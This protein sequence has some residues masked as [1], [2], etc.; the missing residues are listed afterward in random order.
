MSALTSLSPWL[1]GV[2]VVGVGLLIWSIGAIAADRSL[3]T[4]TLSE[5]N[6]VGG[7]NFSFLEPV[8]AVVL[9]YALPLTWSNYNGLADQIGIESSALRVIERTAAGLPSPLDTRLEAAVRSYAAAVAASE[10]PAME[11]GQA[12]P[13][14]AAALERL[15][16]VF[17][18]ARAT[19]P[20]ETM[21][22]RL[23]QRLLAKVVD[24][25]SARLSLVA[26]KDGPA[27]W[28]IAVVVTLAVLAFTWFFG[29]PTLATK[30]VMGGL[31]VAA[32]MTIVYVIF[33]LR[34]PLSGTLGLPATP[35]LALAG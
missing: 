4:V 28:A 32:V 27:T 19:G 12:S 16:S 13:E 31:F 34:H 17:G 22:L 8:L 1:V 25:R 35:Y 14:A 33:I 24:S 21:A 11:N 6:V 7:F 18:D 23:S 9:F 15:T 30:L 26:A 29:L 3:A 20:R 10:W 5:S 2:V